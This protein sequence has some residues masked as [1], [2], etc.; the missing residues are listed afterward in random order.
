M[1]DSGYG[2]GDYIRAIEKHSSC[3]ILAIKN[4]SWLKKEIKSHDFKNYKK[5]IVEDDYGYREFTACR[6]AWLPEE[7]K[8]EEIHLEGLRVVVV[9]LPVEEKDGTPRFQ[10]LVTNLTGDWNSEEV[11]QIYKQHRESI[12]I[13]N[14]EIKNQLGLNDLPSQTLNGN[15]GMAQ[16]IFLAW[17]IMRMVETVGSQK[18]R[19]RENAARE[20]LQQKE[21]KSAE[22][23]TIRAKVQELKGR[24]LRYEWWTIFVRFISTGGKYTEASKMKH[25]IVSANEAFKEWYESI[26]QFNWKDFSLT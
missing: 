12:E 9:R 10:Y 23:Q 2:F 24:L 18:Q 20:R 14:D 22:K 4:D 3:F 6:D 5:G 15:R 17:N 8:P 26:S 19:D 21:K 16:L 7:A 25:V 1:A 13:M 11:H